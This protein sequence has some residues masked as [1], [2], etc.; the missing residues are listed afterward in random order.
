MKGLDYYKRFSYMIPYSLSS[1]QRAFLLTYFGIGS[2]VDP[3]R[4]DLVAGLGDIT[5]ENQLK[6]M[7]QILNRTQ[8]GR[9][10]LK[11]KPLITKESLDVTRLRS[12]SSNTLGNLYINFMDK[13]G[14]SADE[15]SKVR[16]ISNPDI[17]YVMTRYRQVH[18]FWH[19]LS[20]LPPTVLGEVALKWFEF[21]V[22]GLPICVMSG[23][24]GPLK[25]TLNEKHKL[26]TV[27]MP[28]AFRNESK[29]E[30]LLTYRYED[31]LHKH[32]DEVRA[33]LK[34]EPATVT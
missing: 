8:S 29:F 27:Y 15:R 14:F 32:I 4:G 24:L 31:N 18:D 23:V 13:H 30:D 25:L 9:N 33:E 1:S 5:G 21:K 2:L 20:G 26:A 17:A 12:L 6:K 28:W 10:L 11:D 3:T 16:Y 22:T 34:I 7:H 19:V